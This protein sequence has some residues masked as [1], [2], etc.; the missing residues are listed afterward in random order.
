MMISAGV[1]A[2]WLIGITV[3]LAVLIVRSFGGK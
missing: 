3:T 1:V 2:W